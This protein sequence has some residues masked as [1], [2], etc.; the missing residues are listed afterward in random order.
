MKPQNFSQKA[1]KMNARAECHY[2]HLD[3]FQMVG[4][5]LVFTPC[6][7]LGLFRRFGGMNQ[8]HCM[9]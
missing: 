4:I 7:V 9:V 8:V 3:V 6:N 1:V 5:I 2:V